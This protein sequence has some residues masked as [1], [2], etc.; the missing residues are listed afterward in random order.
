VDQIVGDPRV[1]GVF[2]EQRLKDAGCLE[3][4]GECLVG[5]Q[6]CD[7]EYERVEDLRFDVLLIA[8]RHAFHSLLKCRCPR[9]VIGSL[10]ILEERAESVYVVAFALGLGAHTLRLRHLR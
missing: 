8:R 5:G 10:P 9:S 6:R 1:V 2:L 7:V 3:L 4:V